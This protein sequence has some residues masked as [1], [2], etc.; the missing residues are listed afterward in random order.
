MGSKNLKAV[1]VRGTKGVR[2]AK[3][4][5]FMKFGYQGVPCLLIEIYHYISAK[6]NMKR[7]FEWKGVIHQVKTSERNLFFDPV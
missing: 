2:V 4:K 1:A 5:I 7:V 3:P 6:N